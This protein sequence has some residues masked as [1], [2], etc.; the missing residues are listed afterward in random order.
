MSGKTQDIRAEAQA[1]TG[2]GAAFADTTSDPKE[3]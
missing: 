1:G 2:T 3:V